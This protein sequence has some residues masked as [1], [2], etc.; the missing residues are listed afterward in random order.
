[1]TR[2]RILVRKPGL[3]DVPELEYHADTVLTKRL[4][5]SLSHSGAKT[6]ANP[7]LTPAHFAHEREH[8]REAKRAFDFGHV[9]HAFLLGTGLEIAEIPADTLAKDGGATTTA[10]KAFVADARARGA[11]PMKPDEI[12]R[13]RDMVDAAHQ[14]PRVR[15]ILDRTEHIEQSAYWIDEQTGVTRRARYDAIS[16]TSRGRLIGVDYKTTA[17]A[18][19]AHRDAFGKSAADFGYDQQQP[20]YVDGLEALGLDDDPGFLFIVQEKAPPYL[21]AV[22]TLPA[23]MV[24]RG[25][26]LNKRALEIYAECESAGDWPGHPLPITEATAPKWYGR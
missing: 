14:H 16:R 8:G 6:L 23:V 22:L 21:V 4:G 17:N 12:Q 15:Q 18:G 3:Y 26:E 9:A 10:A 19:G 24:R 1:M 2:R 13:A 5:R 11:V 25:H 20:W 7:K